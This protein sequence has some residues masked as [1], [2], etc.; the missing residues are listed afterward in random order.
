MV[1]DLRGLLRRLAKDGPWGL[2]LTLAQCLLCSEKL[3]TGDL[4]KVLKACRKVEDWQLACEFL[5]RVRSR[6]P[7][8]FNAY[9]A[10]CCGLGAW[11]QST[12]ALCKMRVAA[13]ESDMVSYNTIL[14]ALRAARWQAAGVILGRAVERRVKSD[15][16]SYNMLLGA[17]QT[18]QTALDVTAR[19]RQMALRP[20][21]VTITALL[22]RYKAVASWR[23]AMSDAQAYSLDLLALNALCNCAARA[24]AWEKCLEALLSGAQCGL[25]ADVVSRNTVLV[26]L[27][28]AWSRALHFACLEA[29]NDI[30][31][32]TLCSVCAT[33]SAW[34]V[35]L[36]LPKRLDAYS[37]SAS[38][39]CWAALQRWPE[40]LLA[41]QVGRKQHM[42]SAQLLSASV[43]ACGPRW[44]QMLELI[45]PAA[46]CEALN[47]AFQGCYDSL[48]WLIA[49][50]LVS[51]MRRWRLERDASGTSSLLRLQ[52]LVGAWR[53]AL[54]PKACWERSWACEAASQPAFFLTRGSRCRSSGTSCPVAMARPRRCWRSCSMP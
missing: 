45:S 29:A 46:P 34:E 44:R 37:L 54:E 48:Q 31:L 42:E 35:T 19:C 23:R 26:A 17:C 20:S 2:R 10:T 25:E 12:R 15:A 52:G 36:S 24:Q 40:A 11:E 28:G 51:A 30:T 18:W 27:E 9:M 1:H 33:S 16:T 47:A 13:V 5:G 38:S 41:L 4:L 6:E 53:R 49:L 32:N 22:S 39:T 14:G 50:T 43:L 3:L 8:V 21:E 7:V